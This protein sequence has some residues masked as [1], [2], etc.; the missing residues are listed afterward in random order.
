M[1]EHLNV[2]VCLR[3]I[4]NLKTAIEWLKSTFLFTRIKKNPEYYGFS[5]EL[6]Y[7]VANKA[8]ENV[9]DEY[10]K[11]LC[12]KNLNDLIEVTL[13]NY[14]DFVK[15]P[16]AQLTPTINGHLMARYCV[17]FETMKSIILNLNP[18]LSDNQNTTIF[19]LVNFVNLNLCIALKIRIL[20]YKQLNILSTSKEFEDIKLR[21]N[22][23]NILNGLNNNGKIPKKQIGKDNLKQNPHIIRYLLNGK[24]KTSAMKINMY[25]LQLKTIVSHEIFLN[26]IQIFNCLSI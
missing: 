10:L 14:C 13:I 11:Q 17:T 5:P 18:Q 1:I 23:K 22:E 20:I 21:T 4:T 19:D 26:M 9:I 15:N 24:V 25:V 7:K 6:K 2:E 12:I 16:K 3:S 8:S